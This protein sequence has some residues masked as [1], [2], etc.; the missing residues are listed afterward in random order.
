MR[1]IFEFDDAWIMF[2]SW[3][4]PKVEEEEEQES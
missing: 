3:L 2:L 1:M 4:S